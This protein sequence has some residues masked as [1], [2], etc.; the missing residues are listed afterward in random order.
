MLILDKLTL[1]TNYNLVDVLNISTILKLSI[2]IIFIFEITYR[3]F[4]SFTNAVNSRD[5]FIKY[6]YFFIL[7]SLII[8]IGNWGDV[9]FIYFQF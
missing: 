2:F 5:K 4:E 7:S 1:T 3:Y 6:S 8:L 9:T